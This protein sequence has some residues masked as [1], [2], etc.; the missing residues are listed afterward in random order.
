MMF[1]S[2]ANSSSSGIFDKDSLIAMPVF[3]E[4]YQS[5]DECKSAL[6]ENL[7]KVTEN[8]SVIGFCVEGYKK[9]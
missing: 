4:Y 3:R 5:Q 7:T 1:A 9:Q 6:K 8:P 2:I